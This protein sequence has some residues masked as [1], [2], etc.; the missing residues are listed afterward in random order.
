MDPL[1]PVVAE[2]RVPATP[3]EAFIA[4]TAHMDQW[5]DANLT[6]DPATFTSIEID[7]DGEVASL[8]D[9]DE[10]HVWGRVTTWEPGAAY[11]QDFWLGHSPDDATTLRVAFDEDD[12]GTR[13]RLE[14]AGWTAATA[15]VRDQFTAWPELLERY[16]AHAS[17]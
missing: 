4:F 3:R 10:R 2:A 5:W 12:G 7:P 17:R 8:H 14:H 13:V 6:A 16:A 11:A 15:D 9:D 1:E